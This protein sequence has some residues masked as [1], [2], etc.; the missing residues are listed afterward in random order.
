LATFDAARLVKANLSA[1]LYNRRWI[2]PSLRGEIAMPSEIVT[3]EGGG[4]TLQSHLFVPDAPGASA[5]GKAAGVLVFPEA[6]GLNDHAKERAERLAKMGYVAM[7]C[8]IHGK[9]EMIDDLPQAMAR[10]QPLYDDPLRLRAIAVA[11]LQTLVARPGAAADKIAAIGFCFGGTMALELARSGAAIKSAVGFHSGLKTKAPAKAGDI[12]ASI[13][14]CIGAD[15]AF[16]P[17]AERAA[18]EAEMRTSGAD[19][20]MHLYG[21]T[22]HSFTSRNAAKRQMPDVIRYDATADARSW[23]S[24][25]ALFTETMAG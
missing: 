6:F 24:M 9:G 8:D 18:F 4:L 19:W 20:Q 15:D 17:P 14:T 10:L 11:A 2:C 21:N 1:A 16:I 25:L 13:L 3:Y 22:V 23:A 5:G 12:K 7:A